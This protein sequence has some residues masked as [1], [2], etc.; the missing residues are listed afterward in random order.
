MF[1][2]FKVQGSRFTCA[3]S[4]FDVRRPAEC[5]ACHGNGKAKQ[6]HKGKGKEW[7]TDHAAPFPCSAMNARIASLLE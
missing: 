6:G 1:L 4:H 3:D 7:V 5:A 2:W